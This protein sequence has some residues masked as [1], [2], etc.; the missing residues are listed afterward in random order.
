MML[1]IG[2]IFL[3]A[4]VVGV[5]I[6][7]GMGLAGATGILFVA[8][9]D[10]S[11][12]V[13]RMY[14]ILSSFPLLAIPLFS[15]IGLLADRCGL[16][17]ELVKWLQML[18]GRMK[19]GMAYINVA[20][21][22][23]MGGVSGT[24]VSDVAALGRLE[25]QMMT[26]AGYS[27]PFSAALTASTAVIAPIVPP[28]VAMVIFGLAAGG[29][30]IGDLFMAGLIPGLVMALG[31]AAMAYFKSRNLDPV[32]FVDRPSLSV[33]TVQTLRILPFVLLP[34]IIVGGIIG[35]VFTVT[36]SAA[37]GVVYTLLIGFV[38]TRTL[39][40][41]D[42][43][44]AVI[45]SSIISSVVGMLMGAGAIVSWIMTRNQ[46]TLHLADYLTSLTA[47]PTVFMMLAAVGLIALGTIM[48]ATALIVALAPLLVPIARK[49]GIDDLQFG[50]VF[51]MSCMIGMITPPVG[52]LLFMTASIADISLEHVYKAILPFVLAGLVMVALLVLFPPLTLWVP[53]LLGHIAG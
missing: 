33:L 28:S 47:D 3:L 25:I 38:V 8:G 7:F 45:Y 1:V 36:E 14:G 52:I 41:R 30:S 34:V 39:S 17:P 51:T 21:S 10:P 40:F 35:G 27:V 23:L 19:G 48:D 18:L 24:A 53:S 29:I 22:L 37:V 32:H 5:P 46:V 11:L 12:L 4:L 26:R 9:L 50:L 15:M 44:D 16:L 49:Y 43:Y 20:A 2:I 31:M 42:V 6:A 13:R